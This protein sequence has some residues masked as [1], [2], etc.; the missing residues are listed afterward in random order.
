MGKYQDSALNVL[1]RQFGYTNIAALMVERAKVWDRF[2]GDIVTDLVNQFFNIDE[3]LPVALENYW[4]KLLGIT[5]VFDD[6]NGNVYTLTDDE[7]REIIKIKLFFWDGTLV[8]LNDFFRNIFKDRGSFFAVDSQDMTM[9]K[10]I[11]GFALTANEAAMFTKFDIFPRPAGI[12]SKVQ[13][14][15]S[16]QKY[17]GFCGVNQY[18]ESPITV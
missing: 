10:F 7:F 14:I 12:G 4:G 6:G 16:D 9:V 15:P 13:V 11:I 5:R 1:E 17:F 3:C 8:S 2:I 18:T